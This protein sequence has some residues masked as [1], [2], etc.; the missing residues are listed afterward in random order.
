MVAQHEDERRR[1][2]LELHDETAQVFSA[3]KLQLG[4]A[5]EEVAPPQAERLG[6]VMELVDEGMASIRSVTEALRPS[7][8]D[9]LG[10]LPALRALVTDFESRTGISSSFAG[11]ESL[12][13]LAEAAEL[14]IFRAV[15]EGL[16][17]VARHA[18][19]ERVAVRVAPVGARL[20]ITIEDDGRGFPPAEGAAEA[21]MGLAGMRERLAALGGEMTIAPAAGTGTRL[22]LTV[23]RPQ[24]AP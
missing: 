17:N 12:P 1:L 22:R 18:E 7:L 24:V 2:S 15:Q 19:A 5:R 10:L 11:P 20:E 14:A 8:L 23:P 4:I 3:V 13:P 9:D 21:R 16:S 6:R